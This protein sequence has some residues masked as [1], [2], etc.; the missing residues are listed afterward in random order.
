MAP[1]AAP[2]D[3]PIPVPTAN[4]NGTRAADRTADVIDMSSAGAAVRRSLPEWVTL[5]LPHYRQLLADGFNP[6]TAPQLADCLA[7]AG[8]GIL[9]PSRARDVCAATKKLAA[10]LG[11]KAEPEPDRESIGAAQ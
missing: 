7:D 5:A 1:T 3:V 11:D 10:E 8:H 6:V 4:A 2:T 9:K